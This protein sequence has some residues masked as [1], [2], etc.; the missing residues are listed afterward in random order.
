VDPARVKV[1][2]ESGIVRGLRLAYGYAPRGERV[3][4][5][6]PYGK[7][8]RLNL[9]GWMGL[10]GRGCLAAYVGNVNTEVFTCFVKK[11]LVPKL[12]PGDIVVWDNASFHKGDELKEMIE[13]RGASIK[14]LP[15]YSPDYNPI[16]MLWSK[17]KHYVKKARAD[18]FKDLE[19]AVKTALGTIKLSD[20]KGWYEHC[21]FNTSM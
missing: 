14:P 15:R 8:K 9:L 20:V 21:G 1:L 17:L 10:D 16:E 12:K 3:Y 2:D 5:R 4:D 6:A 18:T 13:K 11:R 19:P 7:G